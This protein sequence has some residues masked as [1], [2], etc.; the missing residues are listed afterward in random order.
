MSREG[1]NCGKCILTY[2]GNLQR[3]DSDDE[4]FVIGS[5]AELAD[6]LDLGSSRATCESSSLSSRIY[7]NK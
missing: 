6:A 4:I 5:M 2:V 7:D 1:H 3:M